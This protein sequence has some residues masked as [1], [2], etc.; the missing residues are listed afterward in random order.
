[1]GGFFLLLCTSKGLAATT[2]KPS[3][4]NSTKM[5]FEKVTPCQKY[6]QLSHP[7]WEQCDLSITFKSWIPSSRLHTAGI[8]CGRQRGLGTDS[9]DAAQGPLST[10]RSSSS[11][12]CMNCQL[13]RLQA[14][15]SVEPGRH[16]RSA[17]YPL[18][19]G[20]EGMPGKAAWCPGAKDTGSETG[21]AELR[22][23]EPRHLPPL[24]FLNVLEEMMEATQNRCG[25]GRWWWGGDVPW[26]LSG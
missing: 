20:D 9:H 5:E 11:R 6:S 22:V 8:G 13:L 10:K 25:P 26:Q 1:M 4:K 2:L 19:R 7:F 24:S 21:Q 17:S 12:L 23:P 18:L 16:P 3:L 15:K 14:G